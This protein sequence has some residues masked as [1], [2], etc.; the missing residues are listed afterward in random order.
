MGFMAF[1]FYHSIY[2]HFK[3]HNSKLTLALGLGGVILFLVSYINEV[4]H[5]SGDHKHG[6]HLHDV[7]GDET[8]MIYIAITGAILLVSSHILNI[9]KCKCFNSNGVCSSEE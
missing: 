4:I 9:R 6:E 3:L 5:L 1:A 2:K 8:S 7:H